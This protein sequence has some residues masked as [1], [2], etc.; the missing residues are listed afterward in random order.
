MHLQ[1]FNSK[2]IKTQITNNLRISW[3]VLKEKKE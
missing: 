3:E 2:T 1:A